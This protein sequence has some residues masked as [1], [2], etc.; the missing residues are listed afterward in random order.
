[1]TT[2]CCPRHGEPLDPT[3]WECD[4]EADI[5]A[6]DRADGAATDPFVCR[7]TSPLTL[8]DLSRKQ[9]GR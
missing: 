6:A 1:M 2:T 9:S 3:C 7:Q 8:R 5:A 4:V